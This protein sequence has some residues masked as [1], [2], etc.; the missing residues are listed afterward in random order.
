LRRSFR[1][2]RLTDPVTDYGG[3]KPDQIFPNSW[4]IRGFQAKRPGFPGPVLNCS[5]SSPLCN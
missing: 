2:L 3:L 4:K 1:I 5:L